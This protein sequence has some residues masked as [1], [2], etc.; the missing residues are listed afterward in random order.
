MQKTAAP[1]GQR[2]LV[3]A[4]NSPVRVNCCLW[5][6]LVAVQLPMDAQCFGQ[7]PRTLAVV[8]QKPYVYDM[9]L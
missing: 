7:F 3:S 2:N 9:L 4:A 8:C 6:Q 5:H 1:K